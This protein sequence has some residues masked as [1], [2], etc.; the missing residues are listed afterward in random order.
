[1]VAA[2]SPLSSLLFLF[3][4]YTV[5]TTL[6][7]VMNKRM[8]TM[9]LKSFSAPTRTLRSWYN[10]FGKRVERGAWSPTFF[11][12]VW[13]TPEEQWLLVADHERVWIDGQTY[14]LSPVEGHVNGLEG[15]EFPMVAWCHHKT[16][17][18]T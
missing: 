14:E 1:M 11:A 2:P 3:M 10:Q 12:Y 18:L 7:G 4:D 15:L 6:L 8:D 9:T 16:Y 5:G 13:K 17:R